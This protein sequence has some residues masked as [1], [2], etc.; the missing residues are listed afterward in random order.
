MVAP[1]AFPGEAGHGDGGHRLVG[2]GGWVG[3]GGEQEPDAALQLRGRLL[4]VRVGRLVV[5]DV[6]AAVVAAVGVGD[7]GFAT[8]PWTRAP[9]MRT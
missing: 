4:E 7:V 8:R 3:E 9:T 5:V 6:V 1:S 2:Q